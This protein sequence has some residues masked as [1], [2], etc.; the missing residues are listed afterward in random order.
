MDDDVVWR[1]FALH[2][3]QRMQLVSFWLAGTALLVSGLVTAVEKSLDGVAIGLCVV[4]ALSS[5]AFALLDRRT[6]ALILAAE[7]LALA[8]RAS[9]KELGQFAQLLESSNVGRRKVES[10]KVVIQGLELVTGVLFL[11]E[12]VFVLLEH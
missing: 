11:L 10:Y 6:R 1:W 5:L 2:S 3:G 12:L 4:G 9:G 7:Y 8:N